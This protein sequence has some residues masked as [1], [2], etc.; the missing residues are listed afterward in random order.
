M[1]KPIVGVNIDSLAKEAHMGK[2]IYTVN[3]KNNKLE[4]EK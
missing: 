2:L 3:I 1:K 4:S